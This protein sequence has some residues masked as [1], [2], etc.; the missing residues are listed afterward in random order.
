MQAETGKGSWRAKGILHVSI[1]L[2]VRLMLRS[3]PLRLA[4][5]VRW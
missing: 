1:D 4:R 3:L 5:H 2:M